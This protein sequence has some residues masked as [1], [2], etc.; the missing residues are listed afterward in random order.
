MKYWQG[1]LLGCLPGLVIGSIAQLLL[2]KKDDVSVFQALVTS[3]ALWI[4]Y[5]IVGALIAE[6]GM[7]LLK[8]Q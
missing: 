2:W 8:R 3:P 1:M 7:R 4:L 6:H 5:L